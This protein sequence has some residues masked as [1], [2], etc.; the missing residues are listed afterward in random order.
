M[1][2]S[3]Y[4]GYLAVN[5][6]L[7]AGELFAFVFLVQYLIEFTNVSFSYNNDKNVLQEVS[8]KVER[9]R[10]IALVGASSSGKSTV[11]NL[12][13]GFYEPQ[14]GGIFTITDKSQNDKTGSVESESS[15][16]SPRYIFI[17]RNNNG[18]YYLW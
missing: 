6:E 10:T 13:S 3:I 14:E 1:I 2:C 15:C 7:T 17:S 8:F 12:I 4:G 16:C 9:N 11:F 5:N 18:K